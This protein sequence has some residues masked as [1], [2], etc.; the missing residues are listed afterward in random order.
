MPIHE[1]KDR[2]SSVIATVA[3]TGEEV[4]VTRHGK[5]V[6]RLVPPRGSGVVLGLGARPDIDIPTVEDLRW[7][8][9]EI[10]QMVDEPIVPR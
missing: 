9:D 3:Q 10:A 8:D 5:V 6:A 2:L 7:T 1:L 4:E